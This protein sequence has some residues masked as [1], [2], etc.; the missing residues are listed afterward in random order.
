MNV[1]R[2]AGSALTV[3]VVI[4]LLGAS[5][6]SAA[7]PLL[8]PANGQAITGVSGLTFVRFPP[9][10]YHCQKD[11]FTGV[12][13]SR[14]LITNATVHFLECVSIKESGGASCPVN[15]V[16]AATGLILW[17][18]L[19]GF[20]GRSLPDGGRVLLWLPASGKIFTTLES[21]ACTEETVITGNV[22]STIGPTGKL[23]TTGKFVFALTGGKQ[24]ITDVDLSPGLGLVVPKLIGFSVAGTVEQTEEVTFSEAIEVT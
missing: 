24:N 21:N 18:G 1:T 4:S 19:H 14:A 15:S 23:I 8:L 2:L 5:T 3:F 6:S 16:G 22:A 10:L 7:E 11:V 12:V 9:G 20:L 13:G 17:R